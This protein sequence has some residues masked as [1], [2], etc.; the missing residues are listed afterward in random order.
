[1]VKHLATS[2]G[3]V[4]PQKLEKL[5]EAY[6]NSKSPPFS[7]Y[8][9][10]DKED[11]MIR[12][13]NFMAV[14]LICAVIFACVGIVGMGYRSQASSSVAWE[15]KTI[16]I[17]PFRGKAGEPVATLNQLGAERWELVQFFPTDPTTNSTV[18]IYFLKRAK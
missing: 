2:E 5:A 6:S 17:N 11:H 9:N 12:A 18:G 13:K 4:T 7:N 16:E 8:N 15:Y 1:L 3:L 10:L 14:A